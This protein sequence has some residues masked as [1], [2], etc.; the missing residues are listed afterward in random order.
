MKETGYKI[1]NQQA[2]HFVT[3]SVV[4]WIGI[5]SRQI[6]KNILVDNLNY[7]IKEKGLTIYAW[8]VMSNHL[9]LLIQSKE[10]NLSKIIR[11]YKSF[12]SKN[13]IKAIKENPQESRKEWMLWMFEQAARNHKRNSNYQI[14][15]HDNHP[16]EL[17][18]N[19]FLDQKMNYIHENP[20]RAGIVQNTEDYL[21][22]SASDYAGVK[23]FVK[24][25]KLK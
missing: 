4:Y 23:G 13:L 7:C 16:E 19:K 1:R 22:S 11:D 17:E 24:I 15:T 14:W 18:S 12:T 10:G 3:F 9:H 2:I 20:V 8:V 25:E 6:Y 21:Y 5:F